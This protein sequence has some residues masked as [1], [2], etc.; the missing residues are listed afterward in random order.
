MPGAATTSFLPSAAHVAGPVSATQSV[1]SNATCMV[2]LWNIVC[3]PCNRYA[4]L[5]KHQ[6][7][8]IL[9]RHSPDEL[10]NGVDDSRRQVPWEPQAGCAVPGSLN[11]NLC[12]PNIRFSMDAE[13]RRGKFATWS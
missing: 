1:P 7:P 11:R 3:P 8:K 2:F 6:P 12:V 9:I 10:W 4:V 5:S 13:N